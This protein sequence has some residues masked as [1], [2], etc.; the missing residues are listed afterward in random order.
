MRPGANSADNSNIKQFG[1]DERLKWRIRTMPQVS[2]ARAVA[3]EIKRLRIL[4]F[5]NGFVRSVLV[6]MIGIIMPLKT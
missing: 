4:I 3:I 2:Y 5:G 6:T 1:M